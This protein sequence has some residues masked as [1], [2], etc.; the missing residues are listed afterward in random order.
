MNLKLN[1]VF[2]F[3]YNEKWLD[4]TF[5][6]Y[7]CFD[8]QL[9]VKQNRNGELYLEDTYWTSD[10][11]TFTL[12]QALERGYLKLKCNLNDVEEC[13]KCDLNYYADEDLFDLS[14]QHGCYKS[15]YKKKDAKRSKEKMERVLNEKICSIESNIKWE[16]SELR[17]TKEKLEKLKNGDMNIYI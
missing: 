8:G 7:H 11:K 4:K 15:F 16:N 13:S 10:N 17:R 2:D 14:C 5:E 9:I 3:R 12:E 6:P 1:D